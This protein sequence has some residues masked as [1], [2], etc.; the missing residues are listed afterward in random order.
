MKETRILK[1]CETMIGTRLKQLRKNINKTQQEVAENLNI[2]RAVLSHIENNRN[3]PDLKTIKVLADYYGVSTDYLVGYTH[4]S[5][6]TSDDIIEL[7][8]MLDENAT[9]SFNG[10]QLTDTEKQRVQDILTTIFWERLEEL[11]KQDQK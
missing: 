7:E 5:W 8:K 6:A 4:P 11:K 1:R 2:N 9:M 3:E 10:K